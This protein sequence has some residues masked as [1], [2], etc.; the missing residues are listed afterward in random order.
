M[1]I[2]IKGKFL[3][4]T[5]IAEEFSIP[6]V[7]T[8]EHQFGVHHSVTGSRYDYYTTLELRSYTA[9]HKGTG[10]SLGY[11]DTPEEAIAEAR[12]KWLAASPEKIAE[13]IAQVNAE[14]WER[15]KQ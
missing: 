11:G 2:R 1:R 3:D 10:C 9:T 15:V 8:T 6:G 4:E 7:D 14:N 5:V 13:C 12:S